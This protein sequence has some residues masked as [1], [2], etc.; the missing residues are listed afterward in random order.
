M[1][2]PAWNRKAPSR[3][4]IAAT[5]SALTVFGA[6]S[7]A[8][9]DVTKQHNHSAQAY[10]QPVAAGYGFPGAQI[11][12][13]YANYGFAAPAQQAYGAPVPFPGYSA[14]VPASAAAPAP[15]YGTPAQ[16]APAP[17]PFIG[18]LFTRWVRNHGQTTG[19]RPKISVSLLNIHRVRGVCW[20]ERTWSFDWGG[21]K[22]A[23]NEFWTQE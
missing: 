16:A 20:T 4:A 12:G 23:L 6:S 22:F 17:Q 1:S 9:A 13:G 18:P 5:I 14:P 10:G 19:R 2:L 15:A 8:S 11:Q 7:V 3:A 21:H